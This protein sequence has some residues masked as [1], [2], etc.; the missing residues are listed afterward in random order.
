MAS[1]QTPPAP[2]K[3]IP[4]GKGKENAAKEVADAAAAAQAPA[5]PAPVEEPPAP[6][7]PG[8]IAQILQHHKDGKTNKEIALLHLD[9]DTAKDKFH[10]TTISI[11][12]TKYKKS[13]PGYD[14]AAAQVARDTKAKEKAEAKAKAIAD[15]A[16]AKE[17]AEAE[18]KVVAAA[19]KKEEPKKDA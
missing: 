4:A 14:P 8:K 18:K 5:T 16:A 17:K 19:A 1:K 11:Q 13:L 10:P 2:N 15:K 7:S 3:G 12:V 6:K 9:G